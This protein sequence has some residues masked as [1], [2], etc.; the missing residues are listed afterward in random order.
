MKRK[1]VLL[2]SL[3]LLTST[4]TAQLYDADHTIEI[5]EA[6]FTSPSD[7]KITYTDD[8][9]ITATCDPDT[10]RCL[11]TGGG[12]S[13]RDIE[14]SCK[15]DDVSISISGQYSA[16]TLVDAEGVRTSTIPGELYCGLGQH[17]IKLI[18]PNTGKTLVSKTFE[19]H[20]SKNGHPNKGYYIVLRLR[21]NN[22]KLEDFFLT[23]EPWYDKDGGALGYNEFPDLDSGR[24]LPKGA[25]FLGSE[26]DR[27]ILDKS[28]EGVWVASY[29]DII[30]PF[31]SALWDHVSYAYDTGDGSAGW[32][33]GDNGGKTHVKNTMKT[34]FGSLTEGPEIDQKCSVADNNYPWNGNCAPLHQNGDYRPQGEIIVAS[35]PS[36]STFADTGDPL[37][38]ADTTHFYVCRTDYKGTKPSNSKV[39]KVQEASRSVM[40]DNWK[41]YR[42]NEANDWQRIE[43]PPGQKV[44]ER[45]N[46]LECVDKDPVTVDVDFF[47]MSGVP[48]KSSGD[49]IIAGFK[50]E[51]SEVAKYESF[52]D[53][54]LK[55]VDA[56]CWMGDDDQRP[57]TSGTGT[58]RLNYDG[59]GDAWVLGE[60]PY[61]TGVNNNTYS[62]IW[63][64][65]QEAVYTS[66]SPPR[67]L[68]PSIYASTRV[69]PFQS[70]EGGRSDKDYSTIRN[71]YINLG[72]GELD[73][74]VSRSDLWDPYS[75]GDDRPYVDSTQTDMFSYSDAFPYCTT[76]T[77]PSSVLANIVCS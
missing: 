41:Y 72:A 5:K 59:S 42:C 17:E 10:G 68:T 73:E 23:N 60:I 75:T 14:V 29:G 2:F 52:M 45:A 16:G 13:L 7:G 53:E 71:E 18:D 11:A 54:D 44:E 32:F 24:A 69:I 20:S 31:N 57:G 50:I 65:S 9:S 77:T 27:N 8:I 36:K 46:K 67:L 66:T 70:V 15:Q 21:N 63:G 43:C 28:D 39:V 74:S 22:A 58:F 30:R 26:A 3:V 38:R 51:S 40:V 6:G 56:E 47:N 62:C 25:L 37:S 34:D 4:T 33:A 12:N 55:Q 64:F 35:E 76:P 48:Q 61:R 1:V 49:S 19:V